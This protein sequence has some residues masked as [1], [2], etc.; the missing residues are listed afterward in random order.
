MKKNGQNSNG[1][2]RTAGNRD[3]LASGVNLIVMD[4]HSAAV[5]ATNLYQRLGLRHNIHIRRLHYHA[6][7]QNGLPLP[8]GKTYRNTTGD[9]EYLKTAFDQARLLGLIPYDVFSASER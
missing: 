7:L 8:S 4:K 6:L 9:Y 1:V 2:Q 3:Q 5:W